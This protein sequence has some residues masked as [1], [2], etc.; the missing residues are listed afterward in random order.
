MKQTIGVDARPLSY[1]LTGNSRY[2]YEVL[3]QIDTDKYEFILFSNKEIHPVFEPLFTEYK[4]KRA[5]IQSGLGFVWLN[6]YLPKS[7]SEFNIDLFWGTLQLLP[8]RRLDIPSVVNYHD[9][10]FISAKETMTF[11]NYLQ[12]KVL[13]RFT[14]ANADRIFC[15]SKNTYNEISEYRQSVTYKLRVVY[16]GV[17]RNLDNVGDPIF[18]DYLFSIGTLEPRKN[19]TTLIEAFIQLKEKQPEY[20]YRLVLAGRLGWGE[21]SLTKKL[22]NGEF[23]ELGIEFVENPDEKVLTNLYRNCKFFL[24]PSVHEGFGLPLLEAMVERKICIATDIPVFRE[25]LDPSID[26][27]VED[28]KNPTNW[29]KAFL[30]LANRKTSVREFSEKTWSW[31]ESARKIEVELDSLLSRKK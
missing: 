3:K 5:K 9:L 20:P 1:G 19:L 23:S 8:F 27:L 11:S 31:K 4:F 12:H 10:N 6:F 13:S 17:S 22:K 14:L 15:L 2:L 16:P 18:K 26:I 30:E 21:E 24:F 29:A 28:T 25:I 7:F